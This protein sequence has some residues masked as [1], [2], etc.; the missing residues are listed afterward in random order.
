[1][2]ELGNGRDE[3]PVVLNATRFLEKRLSKNA[4]EVYDKQGKYMGIVKPSDGKPRTDL[5]KKKATEIFMNME[6]YCEDLN[7]FQNESNFK[8]N[9]RLCSLVSPMMGSGR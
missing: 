8:E 5:K 3:P 6:Y 7:M 1:L 4:I 9:L 2:H